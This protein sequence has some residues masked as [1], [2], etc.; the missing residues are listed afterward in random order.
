ML[1]LPMRPDSLGSLTNDQLFEYLE[2]I[3]I[4]CGRLRRIRHL[5]SEERV[6]E[7]LCRLY[8]NYDT[9]RWLSELRAKAGGK[10]S[11]PGAISVLRGSTGSDQIIQ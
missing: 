9:K 3:G 10:I 8:A 4:D 5:M 6:R 7:G 1:I 11:S 2:G